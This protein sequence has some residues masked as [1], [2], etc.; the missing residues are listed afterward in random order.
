MLERMEDEGGP[1]LLRRKFDRG[2]LTASPRQL[3]IIGSWRGQMSFDDLLVE[4]GGPF[5]GSFE[6]IDRLE[7]DGKSWVRFSHPTLEYCF[8]VEVTADGEM[9]DI[10]PVP[11]E[12]AWEIALARDATRPLRVV[13]EE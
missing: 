13:H 6:V 11:P 5:A 12:E 9:G 10:V 8:D 7:R 2:Q 3:K 4:R 1:Y